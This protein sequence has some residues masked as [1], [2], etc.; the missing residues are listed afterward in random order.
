[1]KKAPKLSKGYLFARR[2]VL[3]MYLTAFLIVG[4][5]H[6]TFAGNFLFRV[7]ER[8]VARFEW[9]GNCQERIEEKTF[10]FGIRFNTI[11]RLQNC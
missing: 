8:T 2:K 7:E 5:A 6:S 4:I 3:T 1:M 11:D 10:V 9:D